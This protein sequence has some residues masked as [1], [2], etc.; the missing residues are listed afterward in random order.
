MGRE[1]DDEI[2]G[3]KK[4]VMGSCKFQSQHTMDLASRFCDTPVRKRR[5]LGRSL[6][7][8]SKRGTKYTNLIVKTLPFSE[9]CSPRFGLINGN[10]EPIKPTETHGQGRTGTE[11]SYYQRACNSS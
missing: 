5:R 7:R 6:S 11:T 3:G 8:T 10:K 2:G 4:S 1:V 9:H